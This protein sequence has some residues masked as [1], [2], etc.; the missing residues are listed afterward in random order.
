MEMV[1]ATMSPS[2]EVDRVA[3]PLNL[4]TAEIEKI[5]RILDGLRAT[6]DTAEPI[7]EPTSPSAL[8]KLARSMYRFRRVRD[9]EFGSSMFHDPRWD[10]LLDLFI[11]SELGRRIS[12]SSACIASSAPSTTALRHLSALVTHGLVRRVSNGHDAR[13][14]WVELTD[15]GHA[16]VASVLSR[17]S[18]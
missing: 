18:T 7:V 12:T 1:S 2:D 10:M 17:W 15:E 13:S 5:G 9:E 14:T 6:I 16:R 11:A 4:V 3:L 8:V